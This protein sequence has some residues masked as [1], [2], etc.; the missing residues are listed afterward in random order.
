MND[1]GN[2]DTGNTQEKFEVGHFR[3]EDAQG[4]T[5]LFHAV[6]GDGYPIR[7]FYDPEAIC[8]ANREGRYISIVARDPQE[9]VIGVT[10]LYRSAPCSVLYE[11][12]VGLVLK[13]YR[14]LGINQR[15]ADFLHHDYIASNPEIEALF[16]EGVCNHVHM[17]KSLSL[18][19]YAEAALEVALMPAAAYAQE[20][21]APGRVATL[22][23]SFCCRPKPQRIFVPAKDERM[24][25]SI[26]ARIKDPRNIE[27]SQAQP[28]AGAI[29]DMQLTLFDFAGV[30]RIMV[31]ILGA[32]FAERILEVEKQA[33]LKGA[34][35]FQVFLDMTQP[36]IGRGVDIL[37]RQG[38]FFGGAFPRWFD[39][40]GLLMQKL[41]CPPDFDDIMLFSSFSRELLDYIRNDWQ[42]AQKKDCSG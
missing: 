4:I 27:V 7:L 29:S 15:L 10:H 24:L 35:V 30:A 6:Y 11:W 3:P 22:S 13:E 26:Y 37:R 28:P 21:S 1:G 18:V 2:H 20:K 25:K 33:R 16:G 41:E 42:R 36:W 40:D 14:S 19:G 12:G 8:A 9:G 23:C 17:Q 5:R 34:I 39:G 31:P 38:Y 32:D